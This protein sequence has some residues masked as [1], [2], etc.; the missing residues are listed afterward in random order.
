MI[1]QNDHVDG[2]NPVSSLEVKKSSTSLAK[3]LSKLE[4][5][6]TEELEQNS[7][8][9]NSI[10]SRTK[11]EDLKKDLRHNIEKVL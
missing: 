4:D 3:A 6:P 7:L 9:L 8:K 1:I 5:S 11:R 2:D 10:T